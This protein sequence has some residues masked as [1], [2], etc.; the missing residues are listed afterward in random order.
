MKS[1]KY[2]T[3]VVIAVV[4]MC[5]SV[6]LA[7]PMGSAFAYL[8]RLSDGGNGAD[9]TF[10][11]M[12]SIYDD[13]ND[14][15]QVGSVVNANGVGV[16]GGDFS[17]AIDFGAGVFDGQNR[18]LAS[19][20]QGPDDDRFTRLNP[21]QKILPTPYALYAQMAGAPWISDGSDLHYNEG[22]VGIGT[23]EPDAKLHVVGNIKIEDGNEGAGKVLMSDASGVGSWQAVAPGIP[24][25]LI[26]MWSGAIASI[27]SGWALCDGTSGTPDLTSRFIMSV[28]DS[29][30]NPGVTGGSSTHNHGAGS[31]AS[32]SHT[33]TG[34]SGSASDRRW[35]DDNSGGSDHWVSGENHNHSFNVNSGGGGTISGSSSEANHIPPYYALAFIIKQ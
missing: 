23:T 7:E 18:W 6:A 16:T 8:G 9:G 31:Y 17:V 1:R 5:S 27:P 35:V 24:T 11:F 15:S 4:V 30:T 2:L 22:N 12:F 29:S 34:S 21:R 25:G 33:H 13:P 32:P 26:S 19:E 3:S 14:G 10:D 20:V 28:P